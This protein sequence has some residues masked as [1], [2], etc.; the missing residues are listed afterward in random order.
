M[1]LGFVHGGEVTSQLDN[2]VG[3]NRAPGDLGQVSLEEGGHGVAV[4]LEG[5]VILLADSALPQALGRVVL[6]EVNLC[7]RVAKRGGVIRLVETNKEKLMCSIHLQ[8][9]IVKTE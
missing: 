7:P 9:H 6:E 3:A 2:I 4:N 5:L 8:G 1:G